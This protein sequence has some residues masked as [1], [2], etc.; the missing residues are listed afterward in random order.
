MAIVNA[1]S[2]YNDTKELLKVSTDLGELMFGVNIDSISA[3]KRL[4]RR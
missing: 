3:E 4:A 2:H 1:V